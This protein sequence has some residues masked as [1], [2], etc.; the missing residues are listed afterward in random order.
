MRTQ[1][2]LVLGGVAVAAYFLYQMV[3]AV[4]TGATSLLNPVS[5]GFA[6]LWVTLTQQPAMM[7]L[8]SVAFPDGNTVAIS[9]LPIRT[10]DASG[11]VY[12][13]YAGHTY[14]LG[15]SD[16]LTGNWPATLVQ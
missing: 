5:A 16:L 15:Q 7:V 10:D 2:G 8:G 12:T 13:Q 11:N 1:D 6:N 9:S 4:K 14:S 3:G